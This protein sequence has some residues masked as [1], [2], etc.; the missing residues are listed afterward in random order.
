MQYPTEGTNSLQPQHYKKVANLE[1]IL[2]S[3]LDSSKLKLLEALINQS[4]LQTKG[5]ILDKAGAKGVFGV[6]LDTYQK[7][8][9]DEPLQ[10]DTTFLVQDSNNFNLK[11]LYSKSKIVPD[12]YN[13]VLLEFRLPS[14]KDN[15]NNLM[16]FFC[17][18]RGCSAFFNNKHSFADHAFIH[19]ASSPFQCPRCPLAFN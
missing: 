9:P 2:E 3:G 1:D 17:K 14:F 10:E 5:M 13:F 11:R 15:Q 7:A 16:I 19:C 4:Y 6:D 12:S 8:K 18:E